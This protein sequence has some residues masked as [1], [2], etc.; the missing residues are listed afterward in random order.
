MKILVCVKTVPATTEVEVDGQFRLK[1]D[2]VKLQLNIADEA[3]LETALALKEMG[4]SVTVL[5]MGPPKVADLLKELFARGVDRAVLLSDPTLAGAD[6]YATAEALRAAISHL[7]GFDAIFC[8]R[9]AMDGE[10]GQVPPMLAALMDIPCITNCEEAEIEEEN[11]LLRRRLEGEYQLLQ[12]P[13][14][15]VVSVCEY[16]K[17]L[18]LASLMGLRRAKDKG[19]EILTAEDVGIDPQKRGLKGSKTKVTAMTAKFP[20]LRKGPKETELLSFAKT[21]ADICREVAL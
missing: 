11:L 7:G 18:R 16:S 13:M 3:A 21:A 1:R 9:R 20:G 4:D 15:C 8:G 2:G 14:P 17:T 6:T 12:T 19:V 5:T 10:T